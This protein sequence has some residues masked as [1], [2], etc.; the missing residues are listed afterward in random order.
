MA[1][2]ALTVADIAAFLGVMS[3]YRADE[4]LAYARD[5]WT[6]ENIERMITH[7]YR[8]VAIDTATQTI[9][10]FIVH[11]PAGGEVA[12]IRT[13][14]TGPLAARRAADAM[15]AWGLRRAVARGLTYAF[16]RHSYPAGVD[17]T[18]V[19]VIRYF[20]AVPAVTRTPD[21]VDANGNTLVTFE[22]FDIPAVIAGIEA[23]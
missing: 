6:P 12:C 15:L 1:I 17:L 5:N 11:P 21:V 14:T 22:T 18:R 19:R 13:L 23:R 20:S 9:G 7:P 4:P 3:A 10:V 2:R 16:G 8:A